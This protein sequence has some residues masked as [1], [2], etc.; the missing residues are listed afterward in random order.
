MIFR[1]THTGS[2]PKLPARRAEHEHYADLA[3]IVRKQVEVGIEVVGNGEIGRPSYV[4]Y[5]STRVKGL[6]GTSG[7]VIVGDLEEF[8]DL[9]F[10]RRQTGGRQFVRPACI[11]ELRY[12]GHEALSRELES[13]RKVCRF[14]GVPDAF[15]TVPSP[16]LATLF[17]DNRAYDNVDEYLQAWARVLKSECD[18]ISD[19]GFIVQVDC[20]DLAMGFHV[21]LH[22][23]TERQFRDRIEKHIDALNFAVSDVPPERSRIHV[24]WGN[25]E[26]PHTCDIP[27]KS[28]LDIVLRARPAGLLVEAANP[29]HAH[30]WELFKEVK[31]PIEKYIVPGV[32]DSTTNFV[33]HPDLVAQRLLN[34]ASCI[35]PERVMAGTDCG[36][37]TFDGPS[38]IDPHVVWAKLR[39][40]AQGACIARARVLGTIEREN[41]NVSMV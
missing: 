11:D 35:P 20:P 5:L 38:K 40:L 16:G 12:S 17:F 27:L 29:R 7:P 9:R 2:L 15:V 34:F 39:N 31:F 14:E 41:D 18:A 22:G 1:T 28:I 3:A 37:A 21:Q 24:C 4:G 36:F 19:A 13:F 23:I 10:T 30:E 6:G 32:I 8:P 33:E 25:Y 26:G